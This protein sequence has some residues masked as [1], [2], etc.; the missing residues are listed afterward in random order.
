MIGDLP[1]SA[2]TLLLC[3]H[4]SS[5]GLHNNLSTMT[6]D[7]SLFS[8]LTSS[9]PL[10]CLYRLGRIHQQSGSHVSAIYRSSTY[11]GCVYDQSIQPHPPN[12]NFHYSSVHKLFLM[13]R[14][15]LQ[16]CLCSKLHPCSN[17]HEVFLPPHVKWQHFRGWQPRGHSY[18][19]YTTKDLVSV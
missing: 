3:P 2:T 17:T 9:C 8:A 16:S 11:K 12:T 4:Q 10:L 1:S 18:P 13:Y 15:M 5:T 7:I 19:L 14:N 6:D